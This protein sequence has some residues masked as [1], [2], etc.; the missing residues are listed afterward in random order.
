MTARARATTSTT[1]PRDRDVSRNVV[2]W[3]L[4]AGNPDHRNRRADVEASPARH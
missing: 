4:N 1:A 2:C 3:I